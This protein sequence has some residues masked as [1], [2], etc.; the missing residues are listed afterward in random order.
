MLED[1]LNVSEKKLV[2]P[3]LDKVLGDDM[4][5][6]LLAADSQSESGELFDAL[7]SRKLEHVILRRRLKGRVNPPD[8]L[9]VKNR[10]DVECPEHL[11][12][13]Y[14]RLRTP[15]ESLF[16]RAKCR[17]NQSRFTWQGLDNVCI[18]FVRRCSWL[19]VCVSCLTS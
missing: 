16:R 11:R 18:H 7:E 9:S 14:H 12:S 1:S 6:E 17:L 5:V 4:D 13:I 10:I 19:M 3:L 15:N 8:V 2:M